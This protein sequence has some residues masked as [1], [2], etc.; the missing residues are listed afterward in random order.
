MKTIE[1]KDRVNDGFF[2][3]KKNDKIY[4]TSFGYSHPFNYPSILIKEIF[5]LSK[6]IDKDEIEVYFDSSSILGKEAINK[7]FVIIYDKNKKDFIYPSKKTINN[8][9]D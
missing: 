7:Y 3:S 5:E 2:I 8:L 9:G 4:I 6:D 1:F